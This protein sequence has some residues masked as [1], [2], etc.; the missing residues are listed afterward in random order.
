MPFFTKKYE[1]LRGAKV[2]ITNKQEKTPLGIPFAGK[3]GNLKR[4]TSL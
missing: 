2:Y 1:L 3:R 4:K